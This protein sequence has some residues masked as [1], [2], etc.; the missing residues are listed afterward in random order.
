MPIRQDPRAVFANALK[1][2]S[3]KKTIDAITVQEIADLSGYSR[4]NFY[5]YFQDKYDLA[6]WSFNYE[7]DLLIK[8]NIHESW[9]FIL[10]LFLKDIKQ[11][12]KYYLDLFSDKNSFSMINTYCQFIIRAMT[13]YMLHKDHAAPVDNMEFFFT[14][15]AYGNTRVVKDWLSKGCITAPEELAKKLVSAFPQALLLYFD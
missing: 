7:G 10:S 11:Y 6:E 14:F 9:S 5:Y 13:D 12:K 4:K 3:L 8:K 2:L 15:V 1:E